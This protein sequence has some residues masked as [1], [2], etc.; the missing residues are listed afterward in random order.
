M[1]NGVQTAV[2]DDVKKTDRQDSRVLRGVGASDQEKE[3]S[4]IAKLGRTIIGR[5]RKDLEALAKK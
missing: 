2:K 3:D 1:A 5:F 4:L